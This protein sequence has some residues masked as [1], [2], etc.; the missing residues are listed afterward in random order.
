MSTQAQ[1][2]RTISAGRKGSSAAQWAV[3]ASM[4]PF[5]FP[6]PIR[7]I[8]LLMVLLFLSV[9][10]D[11][12]RAADFQIQPTM[13]ELGGGVKS[14]AFSVINNGDE[15]INFQISVKAWN[16]DVNGKDVYEDTKD[17]I[18]FPKIMTTGP[19]EQRA[20]RIGYKAP[21]SVNEKTYR[22]FVEEIPS[23]K[24]EADSN[25]KSKISAGITIAFRFATPI[26]V[27]P[28]KPQESAVVEKLDMTRGV[29][30]AM[31]RNTGNVHIKLS[32][33]LLRGKTADGTV[34]FSKEIAGWYILQGLSLPYEA[35][36]PLVNCTD[37]ATIEVS[38]KP[39]NLAINR[40]LNVQKDMCAK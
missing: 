9:H 17:I 18:F 27:K 35:A 26:F 22:L 28:L 23:P 6:A 7:Q 29:V 13:L 37:L 3:S 8:A 14:G 40:T 25:A 11:Y 15:S 4:A 20:I 36:I 1:E 32:S 19:H 2:R 30:K 31:I 5:A 16:Q 38:A 21:L 24:K 33:V 12:A 34:L 39:E 10:T